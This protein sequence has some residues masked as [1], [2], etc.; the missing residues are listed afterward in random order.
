MHCP[1]ATSHQRSLPSLP[2]LIS[3]SPRGFQA[4]AEDAPGCPARA[5][6]R[7]PRCASHTKSCP[8]SLPPPAEASQLPSGLQATLMM[9]S[10]CPTSR[11]SSVLSL[12]SHTYTK[13]SLPPPT[14]RVPSGLQATWR[15][16][17]GCCVGPT[18]RTVAAGYS[19]PA[20]PPKKLPLAR[21]GPSV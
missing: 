15:R 20:H 13:P 12:A 7:S 2:P 4:T 18:P 9:A 16:R 21:K 5:R 19:P 8:P 14:H 10:W 3:T 6:T 17:V 1:L 11:R